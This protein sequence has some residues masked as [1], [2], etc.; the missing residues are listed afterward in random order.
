MASDIK[1]RTLIGPGIKT[2][3]QSIA[4]VRQLVLSEIPYLQLGGP[5]SDLKYL[6]RLSLSKDS[7]A[8]LVFDG[9][10]V[11]GASTGMPFVEELPEFQEPFIK[12]GLSIEEYYYFSFSA[13]L[14]P[15]R[16]RGLAHH[17]FD[18]REEHVR[19]LKRFTKI[20]FASPILPKGLVRPT[21]QTNLETFWQKRGYV[22][23]PEITCRY[24]IL[25]HHFVISLKFWIKDLRTT[26]TIHKT[27]LDELYTWQ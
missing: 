16:S 19:H 26:T 22:K 1:I 15:Y 23:H 18:L 13:L 14:K 24:P 5:E 20:C 7:I 10:K 3:L 9:T 8:V 25:D 4:K 11:I 6:K 12:L 27:D 21:E 2:Y 17:F